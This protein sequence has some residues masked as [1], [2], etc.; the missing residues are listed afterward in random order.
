MMCQEENK[1]RDTYYGY[2]FVFPAFIASAQNTIHGLI[3]CH[4][5]SKSLHSKW[6]AAMGPYSWNSLV[7]TWSPPSRRSWLDRTMEQT[8]VDSITAPV[9]WQYLGLGQGP[10]GGCLCSTSV[11]NMWCCSSSMDRIYGSRN[12]GIEMGM[13]LQLSLVTD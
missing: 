2:R 6:S 1:K 5:I 13:T 8:F 3:Y 12:Q 9:R 10:L 4:G 11:S 7:L